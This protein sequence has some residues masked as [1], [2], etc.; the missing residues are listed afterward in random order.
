[1]R[2]QA[3]LIAVLAALAAFGALAAACGDDN[4]ALTLEEY[5]QRFAAIDAEVDQQIEALYVDFPGDDETDESVPFFKQLYAGFPRVLSGG[6]DDLDELNPPS[7]VEDAHDEFL[8]AGRL[9]Q[10][11]FESAAADAERLETFAEV[12]ALNDSTDPKVQPFIDDFDAAC[13]ALVGVASDN[14]ILTDV[15]CEDEE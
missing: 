7:E 2:R 6:L 13:L 3:L 1:M 15:T 8:R 5:F 4:D 12:I 11:E 10:A 9:L 14:G